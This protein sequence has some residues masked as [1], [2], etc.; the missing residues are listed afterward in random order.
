MGV[1][2][3]RPRDQYGPSNRFRGRVLDTSCHTYNRKPYRVVSKYERKAAK[4]LYA[5]G[6]RNVKTADEEHFLCPE[7]VFYVEKDEG[8][9]IEVVER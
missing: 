3:H 9:E 1:S 2:K 8:V 5:R 6:W 7:C 4:K